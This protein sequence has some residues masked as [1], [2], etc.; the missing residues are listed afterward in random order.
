MII[1][2]WIDDLAIG[3]KGE[4]LRS[5]FFTAY[6]KV[7][8]AKEIETLDLFLGM[9]ITRDRSQRTITLSQEKYIEKLADKFLSSATVR[10]TVSTPAWFLDRAQKRTTTYSELQLSTGAHDDAI[11]HGKPYLELIGSI[12]Y[13]NL[14]TRSDITFHTSYLC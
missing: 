4:K 12:L 8:N 10:K 1:L 14:M 3:Y 11:K 2:V 6:C 5:S 13:A 7:F 9:A